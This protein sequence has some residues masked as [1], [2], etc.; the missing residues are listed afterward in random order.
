[1]KKNDRKWLLP[2]LPVAE[3]TSVDAAGV[4]FR[5]GGIFT[6]KEEQ[7]NGTRGFSRQAALFLLYS[8]LVLAG[9]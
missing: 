2:R 5:P 8:L 4:C 1:M 3:E 7:K 9:V 6:L